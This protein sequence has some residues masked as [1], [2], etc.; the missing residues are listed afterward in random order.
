MNY[1]KEEFLGEMSSRS[2]R[3][4]YPPNVPFKFSCVAMV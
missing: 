1:K 2:D 4:V 3:D